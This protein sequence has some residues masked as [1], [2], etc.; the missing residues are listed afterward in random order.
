MKKR[1]KEILKRGIG[2]AGALTLVISMAGCGQEKKE[3]PASGGETKAQESVKETTAAKADGEKTKISFWHIFPVGSDGYDELDE[4]IMNFNNVQDKYEVE[5]VGYPFLDY[6]SK[7]TTAFAGDVAPDIFFYTLDDV[8]V[9]AANNTIANLTPFIERDKYDLSDLYETEVGFGSYDGQ[10]YALPASSTS[11]MLFYNLDMLEAAGLTEADVPKTWDEL[12]EVAHKMDIVEDGVIKQL[13]YDPTAGQSNYFQ[14]LW[15]TNLDFFDEENNIVINDDAH[16]KVLQWM[17][18]FNKDYPYAQ[19][20]AFTDASKTLG[21]DAFV[22]GRLAM[23]VGTN[24][25]YK[26]LQNSQVPFRYGVATQPIPEGGTRVNWSSCWSYEIFNSKNDDKINGAWEF[27]KYMLTPENQRAF[28]DS[29][30]L[31][32]ASKKANDTLKTDEIMSKI[33]EELPYTSEKKYID[34]A[35]K[36]HEDWNQ[37]M[38]KAVAGTPVDEVMKEA[39]QFYKEKRE[40]YKATN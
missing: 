21:A 13:G 24:D 30:G 15:Q 28:Y 19:R 23:M 18:D 40:N 35:P 5:H 12:Y 27:M 6:F 4:L 17:I 10:Q 36:W 25:E 26:V 14:M 31:L 33:I 9:R 34:F 39:E 37:F 22:S 7:M 3:E 2:I 20:Q 29:Q 32:T 16:K 8:P 38:E 11:R 1:M